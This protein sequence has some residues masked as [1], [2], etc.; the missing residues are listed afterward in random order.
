MSKSI[1]LYPAP[2]LGENVS[3]VYGM[4]VYTCNDFPGHWVGT[5]AV[6]VADT[7]LQAYELLR[8]ELIKQGLEQK[9]LREEKNGVM[10]TLQLVDITKAQAIVLEN[11]D[12]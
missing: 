12:Y 8:T 1:P 9:I 11:G 10:P 5:A 2:K 4:N 6:I 3:V 7:E